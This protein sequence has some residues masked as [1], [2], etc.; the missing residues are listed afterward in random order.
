MSL[1]GL[2]GFFRRSPLLE[3]RIL[4]PAISPEDAEGFSPG[5]RAVSR[6]YNR[7]VRSA[8][9]GRFLLPI[10]PYFQVLARRRR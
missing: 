3:S 2:S 6:L 10:A 5:K 1:R 4:C 9:A 7:L 8:A